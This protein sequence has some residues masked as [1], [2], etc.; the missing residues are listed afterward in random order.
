MTK[1]ELIDEKELKIALFEHTEET[2]K[3]NEKKFAIKLVEKIVF[4][5]I[6]LYLSAVATA[7]IGLVLIK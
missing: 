3:A 4:G 5:L 6:A 7:L 1:Q 2:R